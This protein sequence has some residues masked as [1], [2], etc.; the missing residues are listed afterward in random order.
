M[1][2]DQAVVQSLDVENTNMVSGEF[3]FPV[4]EGID[5]VRKLPKGN[6]TFTQK[7]SLVYISSGSRGGQATLK[8][9]SAEEYRSFLN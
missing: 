4:W 1:A 2:I 3:L 5:L 9:L 6:L 7:D 8:V